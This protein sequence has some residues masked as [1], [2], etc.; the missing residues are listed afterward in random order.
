MKLIK[1]DVFLCES[2]DPKRRLF[3][4][5]IPLPNGTTY[6]SYFVKGKGKNALIDT[7]YSKT[8]DE[9]LQSLN[10]ENKNIDYIVQNHAEGDHSEG[11]LKVLELNPNAKVVTNKK[12][13]E[14]LINQYELNSDNFQIINDGE[15]LDLG[16]K[17]LKFHMAPFVHWPDTMF[18]ELVE[19]K[20]LFTCDYLGAHMTYEEDF[21]APETK[22][23]LESAKRYY[24]EI[25]MPFRMQSQKYIKKVEEI[26]PEI[27]APSHGALY[28]N[29]KFILDAYREWTDDLPKNKV[30]IP[31][32]S[33][34]ENTK[35]MAEFLAKSLVEKGIEAN[36]IDLISGDV[37]DYAME[38]VD[39]ATIVIGASMVLSLPHPMAYFGVYLTNALRPKAKFMSIIGSFAWGG[40]L[41]GK[42]E[43]GL[44]LLKAEKLPYVI[45]KGKPKKEDL[46]KLEE[47][48]K[49]IKEKHESIGIK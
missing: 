32:V 36:A 20:I 28:K 48:A 37:G 16:G 40:N 43:E 34:Y 15:T 17:T 8:L 19:D 6:N 11:I 5:L 31:Y 7:S 38:L 26:A 3:D 41:S 24:A 23:Y 25:M 44:N 9:F 33:M 12:C 13:A 1:N 10:G 2:K 47:L 22:E 45:A 46:E 21:Y 14:I 30:A 39:C 49:L 35:T 4:Q 42:I 29:P 27:V 18:T